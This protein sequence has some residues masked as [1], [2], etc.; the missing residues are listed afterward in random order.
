M[1]ESSSVA[2]QLAA[3]QI[4]F[5]SMESVIPSVSLRCNKNKD[6]WQEHLQFLNNVTSRK[7]N[8]HIPQRISL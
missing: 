3:S 5:S 8:K 4:G 6:I 2:E 7:R 1:F